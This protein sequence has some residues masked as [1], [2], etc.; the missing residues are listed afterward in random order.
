MKN[1]KIKLLAILLVAF[2]FAGCKKYLDINNDPGSP[3][4]PSLP[5][6]LPPVTAV[7]S[8]TMVL[9]GRFSGAYIQNFSNTAAG[10]NNDVHGGNT[11]NGGGNQAWRDFYTTQGTAINSIISQGIA[12]EQWDY[13][14][15]AQALRAWGLQNATDIFSDL[16]Y[17]EAWELNRVY[18]RYD[19]QKT[20]YKVVDSL[21]RVALT[22]LS[23]GDGKVSAVVMGRGDL[24]YAGDRTKW[25]K[26]VYGIL[27]RNWQHQTNKPEYNADSVISYVNKSM[28]SNADNF[29]ITHSGSRNDDSN[30]L[31]PARD[32]F[33]T[34]R[35]S[36]FIVQLLD[37]T[38]FYTNTLGSSRDPRLSR[39]LS[40][41]IDTTTI[42]PNMPTLNGGYRYLVP[43]TGFTIGA[44]GTAAFTQAPST[45]WGD[46]IMLNPG[47]G[48][49]N[50]R[51]G[52]YLFQ[53][54]ARFPIMT[55]FEMQFIK[56]EAA[57]KKGDLTTALTAY[58]EGIGAHIDFVNSINTNANGVTQISVS[59]KNNYL[60]SA[61]VKQTIGTL[62]LTDIMLQKYIAD[63]G[64]NFN[65]SWTDMRRYHY[66]DLDPNT[67][68][69]I[70]RGFSITAFSSLNF[71]PKPAYRSRPTG[72]SE[73]DWNLQELIRI[74][75][76]NQD[77][78]TYE[79][80]FS[81]P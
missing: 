70:Y 13:V 34:R 37:G 64:W 28:G 79:M 77:Y 71:G 48:N 45:F 4:I 53:N 31:G 47:A 73:N 17:Y 66:F 69:Q 55:Y 33:G 80:W 65:E 50:A 22:Y 41:S 54:N 42:T 76:L 74:G 60:G 23:R 11:P 20:L 75:A 81:Q 15:A 27:A 24:V 62:T 14:G 9:D 43:S 51:I 6:L 78:H 18:F 67:L 39:M 26:F 59:E 32:N 38:S 58:K 8:R 57:F 44:A 19:N 21:C 30:P 52:K 40:R 2:T 12:S 61:A 35:Q 49:F 7:M 29:I 46:T 1:I 72:F 10:E 25:T 5:A 16:P 68:Q 56:A 36:R 3:Q 63:F